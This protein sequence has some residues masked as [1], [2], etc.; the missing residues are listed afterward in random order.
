MSI[1]SCKYRLCQ[2][3]SSTVHLHYAPKFSTRL[4]TMTQSQF[5]MLENSHNFSHIAVRS[6]CIQRTKSLSHMIRHLIE[7]VQKVHI[8]HLYTSI[9]PLNNY[10]INNALKAAKL[11]NYDKQMDQPEHHDSF[12]V[13]WGRRTSIPRK[14]K[15]ISITKWYMQ[16]HKPKRNKSLTN[17]SSYK[18]SK[19]LKVQ[20]LA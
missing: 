7:F 17:P 9:T 5:E 13:H 15:Q 16:K 14:R 11:E 4:W 6:L 1:L 2:P 10:H 12:V 8:A 20:R 3:E 19:N 18:Q